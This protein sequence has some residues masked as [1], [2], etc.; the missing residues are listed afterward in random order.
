MNKLVRINKELRDTAI[1][2]GL[3]DEWQKKWEKDISEDMLVKM[4]F[5]GLD[6]CLANRYPSNEYIIKNFD[7]DFRRRNNVFVN[8][9]YSALNPKE[10]LILGKSNITVRYNANHSGSIHVRDNSSVR[11]TA[12][13]NSFVIVHLYD[14]AK[15]DPEIIGSPR[16]VLIKHSDKVTINEKQGIVIKEEYQYLK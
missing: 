10:A 12:K 7:L 5:K 3:C 4:M 1:E 14:N 11:L 2:K 13:N 15:I 6:F 16:I 8:D 9:K